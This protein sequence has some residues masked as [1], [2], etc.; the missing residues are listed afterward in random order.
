[1]TESDL[2][3]NRSTD[4]NVKSDS[5]LLKNGEHKGP[6]LVPGEVFL[7]GWFLITSFA[8]SGIISK[9]TKTGMPSLTG[10]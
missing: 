2:H 9:V 7:W 10:S 6:C 3:H 1:M 4:E 5:Q 8:F